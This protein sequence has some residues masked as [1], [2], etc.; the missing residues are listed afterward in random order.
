MQ[1]NRFSVNFGLYN[2]YHSFREM[3]KETLTVQ[4]R[5][6]AEKNMFTEQ[7]SSIITGSTFSDVVYNFKI[8]SFLAYVVSRDEAG[9]A[10]GMLTIHKKCPLKSKLVF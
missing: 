9:S 10:R 1:N 7:L 4:V 3:H 5:P 2:T 8:I 6:E